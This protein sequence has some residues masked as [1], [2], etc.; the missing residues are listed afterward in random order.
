MRQL[1]QYRRSAEQLGQDSV[2]QNDLESSAKA[3]QEAYLLYVR[4]R[5]EARMA[6][7]A[8]ERG[9]VDS[10]IAERPI[11]PALPVW[12]AWM[13]LLAGCCGASFA[14]TLAAFATDAFDPAFRTP[15][16]VMAYL[17]TP[18]LACLPT[19]G[20]TSAS[21]VPPQRPSQS[22]HSRWEEGA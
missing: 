17:E 11:V 10:V 3:A 6:D 18:V 19:A 16:E 21:G 2:T 5:E 9:I 7:A 22:A 1:A 20:A 13:V 15:E 4:K 12:P 14:A 8:D